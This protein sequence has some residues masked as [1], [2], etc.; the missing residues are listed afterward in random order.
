[1]DEEDESSKPEEIANIS[2]LA[3]GFQLY[4]LIRERQR[5]AGTL[6]PPLLSPT[7]KVILA[8]YD[9]L[10]TSP[11]WPLRLGRG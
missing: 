1:M 2:K 6:R 7:Q 9:T 4:L 8:K 10:L 11:R 3:S 5:K